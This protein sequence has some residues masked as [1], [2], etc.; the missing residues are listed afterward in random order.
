MHLSAH[1][2]IT[3][4]AL[5]LCNWQGLLQHRILLLPYACVSTALEARIF[6]ALKHHLRAASQVRLA[7]LCKAHCRRALWFVSAIKPHS[8]ISMWIPGHTLHHL[9]QASTL[10]R[11]FCQ[12]IYLPHFNIL[13]LLHWTKTLSK[14]HLLTFCQNPQNTR[15]LIP[16]DIFLWTIW[17]LTRTAILLAVKPCHFHNEIPSES[18]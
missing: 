12:H 6:V 3:F 1:R 8:H 7:R 16:A 13:S 9:T 10:L 17:H 5:P 2:L 11:L 4:N 15:T 14:P 18:Y